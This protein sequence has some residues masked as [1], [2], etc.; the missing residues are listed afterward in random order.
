MK[1]TFK[2][3][4]LDLVEWHNPTIFV[5]TETRI[6]GNRANDIIRR[7]PLDGAY[8]IETLGHAG[9][10]WLLWHSDIVSMDVLFVMEQEIHVIVQV[11]PQ[12]QPWLLSAIYGS[13][14]FRERCVQWENSKIL[15]NRR[16]LPWAAMGDFNDVTCEEEKFFGNGI[17]RRVT[18][19]TRCMDYC[20]L[21]D[22][23]FSG[24]K[25]TWTNKRDIT[26]LIQ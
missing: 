10:I 2:K 14:C 24:I 9:G 6:D 12:S 21:I 19:Y 23:G 5:I 18:K 1:P 8:S 4:I 15:S 7:L 26:D 13:P 22:L 25:Y 20:N 11:S 16:N 3:T 17:C